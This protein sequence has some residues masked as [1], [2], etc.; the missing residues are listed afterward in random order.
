MKKMKKMNMG[1]S[2]ID[3]DVRAR[4]L[5]S[6]MPDDSPAGTTG[7]G[8]QNELPEIKATPTKKAAPSF[9]DKAK[10][11]GFTSAETKGGAAL[12]TR[13][14]R[15]ASKPAAPKKAA[16]KASGSDD[17]DYSQNVI[18]AKKGG[19]MY[20]SASKRADGCATKGKTRGRMV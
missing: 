2:S 10:K 18:G 9:S 7:Y 1:G 13:K 6:V 15:S 4:A 11:A 12:M 19:V 20:S 3:D 17:M 8:E 16:K 14:D 5:R